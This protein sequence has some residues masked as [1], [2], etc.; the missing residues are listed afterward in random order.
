MSKDAFFIRNTLSISAVELFWGMGLPVVIESTFL[1]LFLKNLGASSLL[2]G[3]VPTL[4][5]IGI[6]FFSLFSGLL[7]GHLKKKRNAVLSLHLL[8]SMPILFF[9]IFLNI[10]GFGSETLK[11]FFILYPLF[12]ISIGL[13]LPAW[14]NYVTGIYS[15]EKLLSGHSFMWIS[16]SMGKFF[17]G[18]F[19]LKVVTKYSFSYHGSALIFSMVGILFITG[20]LFFLFTTEV[21][22]TKNKTFETESHSGKHKFLNDLGLAL[23]NRSYLL[24]LASDVELF[25][26]I[27]ILSFYA[28][29]AV[30]YRGIEAGTAAGGFIILNYLGMITINVIY[31]RSPSLKLKH[32]YIAGKFISLAAA[33]VLCFFS[34]TIAFFTVSFLMGVS[35]GARSLVYMPTIKKISGA[36]D[37]TNFFGIAPLL[38]MPLSTGIPL[39]SG[40]FLDKLS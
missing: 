17:G 30:T 39:L 25:A 32:K 28:N 9:G 3:L 38:T 15:G 1:Q 7:T 12:S 20:S 26:L 23:R 36:E 21:S 11:V 31:G 18:F 40:A 27:T 8:A 24:L 4:F 5:F 22:E 10:H 14:Q 34:S 37:A 16:Q 19:I 35:R 2:I 33:L 13:L 29:Y 6:S